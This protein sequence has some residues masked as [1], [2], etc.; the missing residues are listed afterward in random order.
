M[1]NHSKLD[2]YIKQLET[3]IP[4]YEI[5]NSKISKSTVGWQIDHS[6]KVING[7]I[8]LLKDAPTDKTPKLRFSGRLFLTLGYI[9]RGMGKA[10][11]HVLPPEHIE[12]IQLDEQLAMAK[13]LVP[14]LKNVNTKATF[15]HPYFG[16]LTKQQSIRFIEVHTK[17]H[18]KIIK[19]ILKG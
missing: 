2:S 18:L 12:K 16:I 11:K 5:S 10:P 19:D 8:G 4:E 6:L 1:K 9:P 13:E 17:H 3:H 7:I 14:E 15:K